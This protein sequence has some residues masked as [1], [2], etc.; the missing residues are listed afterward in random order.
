MLSIDM[1]NRQIALTEKAYRE[2]FAANDF[3]RATERGMEIGELKARKFQIENP[4]F[5]NLV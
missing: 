5:A 4:N 3:E 1:I 2:A